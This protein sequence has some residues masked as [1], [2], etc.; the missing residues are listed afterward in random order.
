ML[1]EELGGVDRLAGDSE[2]GQVRGD[3]GGA[4]QQVSICHIVNGNRSDQS[5]V[6]G[7]LSNW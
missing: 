4:G 3:R 1:N 2:M 6:T 5:M 7:H